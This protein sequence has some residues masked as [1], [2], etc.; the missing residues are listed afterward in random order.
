MNLLHKIKI[1]NIKG[2]DVFEVTF[3]D[4]TANQPNIVVAPSGYGKSTIATAF[5]AAANG[6]MKISEKDLYQHNPD[7]HPKLE[8]ELCGENAGTYVSTDTE[9]NI[10]RNITL[11]TINS[12][13]YAKITTRGFGRNVAA[14]AD[15]R[16]EQ[17]V[18][19]SRIPESL[20]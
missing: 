3:V 19:Y 15:L 6:K 20:V 1:E 11:Y 7:N 10:S 12:P 16:V 8:V 18:V 2:K 9:G 17:V 13:L 4:L 14:T 5:E